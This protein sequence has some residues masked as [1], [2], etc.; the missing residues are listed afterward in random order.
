M[1]RHHSDGTNFCGIN[2]CFGKRGSGLPKGQ[3]LR[4]QL[5]EHSYL[6]VSPP[7]FEFILSNMRIEVGADC[8]AGLIAALLRALKSYA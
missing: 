7:S 5:H 4:L 3:L 6:L 8:S 2:H 1:V